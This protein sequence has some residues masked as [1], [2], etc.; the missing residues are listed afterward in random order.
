ML[1]CLLKAQ[2]LLSA[3]QK[4]G[5]YVYIFISTHAHTHTTSV[6]VGEQPW[7][8]VL[9]FCH[10]GSED[11][12]QIVSLGGKHLDQLSHLSRP[13]LG[14]LG[15]QLDS[16]W[17][18]VLPRLSANNKN[19]LPTEILKWNNAYVDMNSLYSLAH[20]SGS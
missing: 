20:I 15:K 17:I 7:E 4:L 18:L 6:G 1:D 3:Y 16:L 13:S 14:T 12:T 11:G 19:T 9:S 2:A 8:W 5:F 10:V